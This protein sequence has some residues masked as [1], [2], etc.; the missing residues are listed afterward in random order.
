MK[1]SILMLA[2]SVLTVIFTIST[3]SAQAQTMAR[4]DV[5]NMVVKAI[6]YPESAIDNHLQGDVVVS[7]SPNKQGRLEVMEIFSRIPILKNYVYDRITALQLP[8]PAD[9]LLEPIVL[10]FT[11]KLI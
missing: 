9:E 5:K 10:R 7:F 3:S 11:F 2:L 6:A 8:A 1:K 4:D